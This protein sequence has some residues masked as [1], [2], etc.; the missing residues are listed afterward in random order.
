MVAR[1]SIVSVR[2]LPDGVEVLP[3]MSVV[4]IPVLPAGVVVLALAS[5]FSVRIPP[6]GVVVVTHMSVVSVRFWCWLARRSFPS[7]SCL[8]AWWCDRFRVFPVV[9]R[10]SVVS[11]RVLPDGVV[12]VARVSVV[13]NT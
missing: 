11:G 6:D 2:V 13:S 4:S 1:V 3:L 7:E 9:A 8:T 10:V 5:A 12:A